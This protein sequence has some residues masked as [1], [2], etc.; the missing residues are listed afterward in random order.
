LGRRSA[1]G[2]ILDAPR[3]DACVDAKSG[4]AYTIA[5]DSLARGSHT[6][7]RIPDGRADG[8]LGFKH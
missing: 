1:I 3:E 8:K 4:A 5:N 6:D 7:C 2:K